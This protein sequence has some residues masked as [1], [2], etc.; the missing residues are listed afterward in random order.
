M[1]KIGCGSEAGAAEAVKIGIRSPF[2]ARVI[3]YVVSDA[4]I[5]LRQ[6]LLPAGERAH[7]P[8]AR[9]QRRRVEEYRVVAAAFGRE[10]HGGLYGIA[11]WLDADAV[12]VKLDDGTV[13]EA[14]VGVEVEGWYTGDVPA[15]RNPAAVG[16][17]GA[18]VAL[19]CFAAGGKGGECGQGEAADT[20]SNAHGAVSPCESWQPEAV[21]GPS[22]GA[23]VR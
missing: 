11:I 21:G 6:L 8:V 12:V 16:A 22:G 1:L 2:G 18:I 7:A 20:A 23:S 13:A 5:G 14:L 19:L 10:E 17:R 9:E 15:A 4:V 3:G